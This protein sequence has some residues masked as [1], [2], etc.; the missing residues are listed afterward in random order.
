[1]AKNSEKEIARLRDEIRYH[2]HRYYVLDD[3]EISD[4]EFDALMQRLKELE[5]KHPELVTPDSPT[6]RVGGQ[7]AGEF[8]KVRHPAPMLSLANTYS[9]DDL[10]DF[11]RRVRELAGRATVEYVA[12]LK[13]DGLSMALTYQ[14]GRLVHGVT[15][16][17]G[18]TGEDVT[19]NVKTIRSVPLRLEPKK[20]EII[21]NPARFEVRGEV[22]MTHQA[23]E[24]MNAQ[25]E[26][27]GEPKFA[28]PR[29]AAAGTMRQLDPRIVAERKLDM[30]VYY[31]QVK[32]TEPLAEHAQAL[33]TLVELGFKVNPN[34]QLCRTMDDLLAYI[35]QWETKRD[36]LGYEIDGIVI[37]VNNTRLWLE[38]GTTA[39]SPRWAV[40][41]KYPARQATTR[42]N[43]IRAQVGRTGTLTPVA[44]LEPVDVGGVT[45]SHATLHNLDE[46]ARLGVKIGDTV[47]IQRAGEVI[48][49]VVKVV[50]AAPD[51]REFVMPQKCP[52][53]GGEVHRAEGEVAFRCVNTAC[54]AK[55]KESLL[56]FAG[57]RAMNIDGLGEALV[58][59]LVDSEAVKDVA[60]LYSLTKARLVG[61][62]RSRESEAE[63]LG[64]VIQ[65]Y[66]IPSVGNKTAS[67][68]AKYFGSLESLQK[69]SFDQLSAI[70][71]VS[72]TTAENIVRF[73]EKSTQQN[74]AVLERN[75]DKWAENVL[76]EINKSKPAGLARLI[77]ALG[78]RF[79]GERTAQLLAAH[80]GSLKSLSEATL[81]ELAKV[82]EVGPKVGQSIVEFFGESTNRKILHRLQRAGV[83]VEEEQK[84]S[85]GTR[86]EGKTFVLTG[87]FNRWTREEAKRLIESQAGKVTDSVSKKTG[88]VVVGSQ[89]GSK[90]SQAIALGVTTLDEG[91]LAALLGEAS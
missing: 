51:G 71:G 2:E 82:Q 34:W 10:E 7:P 85:K 91:Q 65:A 64:R 20:L 14:D 70:K 44:D 83:T 11:D 43:A 38:L 52:V 9:V 3:P 16:G 90:Y 42:V 73:F 5:Q 89:P 41:Y 18:E 81:D 15:R 24:Q 67:C 46:I 88:Y 23:F 26:A 31:L 47:L 61:V 45:V 13:L 74:L 84:Q 32:G 39:K 58:D 68:L 86:L 25:R 4:F 78:I 54:P 72:R 30:F 28:N 21:A 27:A 77:F 75:A 76:D 60:D 6:Q 35:Q 19:T 50:K 55:L 48:P 87:T 12:E 57:R 63:R 56:Y 22:I 29:N 36:G 53:C 59:E 17:D 37:K 62:R 33:R 49:Q 79:V 8:P 80:F 40:A 1:M 69:A 66:K